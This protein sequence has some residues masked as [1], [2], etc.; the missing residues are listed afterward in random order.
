MLQ[1]KEKKEPKKFGD[2]GNIYPLMNKLLWHEEHNETESTNENL[3][4]EQQEYKMYKRREHKRYLDQQKV[5]LLNNHV[6]QSM[7]YLTYFFKYVSTYKVL[8]KIFENDIKDLLGLRV[9]GP[10]SEEY[11]LILSDLLHS[12]LSI[13]FSN[14]NSR[15]E[16]I[17]ILQEIIREKVEEYVGSTQRNENIKNIILCDFDR[18]SAWTAMLAEGVAQTTEDELQ[19]HRTISFEGRLSL[20]EDERPLLH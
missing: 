12:I 19:P 1:Q 10:E 2:K 9:K 15:L 11:A 18:L 3:T 16:L 5:D 4:N 13:E 20:H 8:N 17:H 14:K 6:F 7:A